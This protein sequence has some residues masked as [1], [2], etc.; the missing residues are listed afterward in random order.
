MRNSDIDDVKSV[1]GEFFNSKAMEF[2][3]RAIFFYDKDDKK[4]YLI[5]ADIF[6][7]RLHIYYCVHLLVVSKTGRTG[8]IYIYVYAVVILRNIR[9]LIW[10]NYDQLQYVG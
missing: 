6:I 7:L 10:G 1:L 8:Y 2:Y 3:H 4:I 9:N 5:M